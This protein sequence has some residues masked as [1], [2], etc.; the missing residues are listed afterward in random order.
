M[1]NPFKLFTSWYLEAS[2]LPKYNAMAL[3]T[4]DKNSTPSVRIV[5]LKDHSNKG[6][7]FYTNI[8]S[9]KGKDIYHN[10]KAEILFFWAELAKQIR[11]S[12]SIRE[13][14]DELS[15][16]YFSKRNRGSQISA[17]ASK[18]SEKIPNGENLLDKYE[19]MKKKFSNTNQIPRPDFWRGFILI[20]NKF[21]FWQEQEHR[22]HNR[23]QYNLVNQNDWK[24]KKL[25]P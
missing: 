15:D 9:N 11:I 23:L 22:L 18:Q 17:W 12:G 3:A 16:D 4:A 13:L 2:P 8:N 10:P 6:F 21:E 5:L 20:P 19:K 14:D 7:T 1:N 24:V 25:Y